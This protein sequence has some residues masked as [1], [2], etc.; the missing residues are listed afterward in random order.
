MAAL[1]VA[2][3]GLL[4]VTFVGLAQSWHDN[5][6]Y[7]ALGPQKGYYFLRPGSRL[8]HQLGFDGAP[9]IDTADPFRHGLWRGRARFPF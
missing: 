4:S 5:S 1:R 9:T 3:I 2:I 8:Q 7:V 6:H